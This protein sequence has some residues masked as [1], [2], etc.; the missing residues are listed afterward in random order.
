MHE[1]SMSRSLLH[2][3]YTKAGSSYLQGWFAAHP[4]LHYAH[5]ALHGFRRTPEISTFA[6]EAAADPAYFVTSDEDLAFWKGPLEPL[7]LE[8][9]PYD[10]RGHQRR[11]CALLRHLFPQ[12]TVLIVTRGFASVIG[13]AYAQYV[14]AGGRLDFPELQRATQDLMVDFWNYDYLVDLYR[15]AFG[16]GNVVVLPY[17][18][19]LRD[20]EDFLRRLASRLGL[21]HLP[22]PAERVNPALDGRVIERVRRLSRGI[23]RMLRPLPRAT[24]R[25]IY[26]A[27]T[28]ALAGE[29]LVRL[30]GHRMRPDAR[31]S[32]F[33]PPAEFLLRFRG[34]A[35]RLCAD[36]A[37]AEF[38]AEYLEAPRAAAAPTGSVVPGDRR[39]SFA[40]AQVLS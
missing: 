3:G 37:Y 36:S 11:V 29:P 12:A 32:T 2:I 19:L 9:R 38:C 25:S 39:E 8:M 15:E 26:A 21:Q 16:S 28:R 24:Q 23:L 10:V 5:Q 14:R 35:A 6:H 33:A 27:Y 31:S 22:H 1:P 30:L 7:G 18:L 20:S 34:R 4:E 40:A 13:S 17:E